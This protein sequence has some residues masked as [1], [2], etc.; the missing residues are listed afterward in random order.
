[1]AITKQ[2]YSVP[3]GWTTPQLANMLLSAFIDAGLMTG[4][5]D[6]FLSGSV[7]NR[8]LR[9]QYDP[10]KTYGTTFYWFQFTTNQG[11]HLHVATGWDTVGKVP[12]GTQ[13]LDFFA[14]TTNST[15]NHW[16]VSSTSNVSTYELVRYTSG[17]DPLQ[18]WFVLK[19]GSLRKAFTIVHADSALQPWLDLDKGMFCGFFHYVPEPASHAGRISFFRGP[20]VRRDVVAGAALNG[21]TSANS[22]SQWMAAIACSGYGA[23]GNSVDT[24]GSLSSNGRSILTSAIL[25]PVNFSGTNPAFTSNSTPVYHSMPYAPYMVNPFPSD[26]GL[27]FHYATNT[28][29]PGDTLV[30]SPGVE[31]WEVLDYHAN[32]SA[33]TGASSLFLARV[34]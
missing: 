7:E 20:G 13:F 33:I 1:M 2:T 4:W 26:F 23:V 28:F 6:S 5:H 8:I 15:S 14:T 22:Y 30:V 16:Q 11:V 29:S 12:T 17:V 34:V 27:T 32:S 18:T 24:S 19:A 25:L 31:E 10:T 3:A 9:V 21:N